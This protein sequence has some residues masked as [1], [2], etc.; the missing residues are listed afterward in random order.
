MAWVVGGNTIGSNGL[1]RWGSSPP[2]LLTYLMAHYHG[3]GRSRGGGGLRPRVCA[4]AGSVCP[5]Q[6][7]CASITHDAPTDLQVR[8]IEQARDLN[9]KA[10]RS[11]SCVAWGRH[12]VWRSRTS[13]RVDCSCGV[14]H[15][16][17]H[18][19]CSLRE[20]EYTC[21]L[22]ANLRA[23]SMQDAASYIIDHTS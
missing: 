7:A 2:Q 5:S 21:A 18:R 8:S 20:L 9:P 11:V 4:A 12:T 22:S 6:I 15:H 3:V 13:A 19:V 16:P 14:F 17:W 1:H 23:C 10:W